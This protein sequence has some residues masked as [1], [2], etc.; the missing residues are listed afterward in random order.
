MKSESKTISNTNALEA[1]ITSIIA[2]LGYELVFAEITRS[3][4]RKLRLFIDHADSIDDKKITL[5]DCVTVSRAL[6]EPL[7]SSPQIDA[8]FGDNAYELEVSSPGIDRPLRAEADYNKFKGKTARIHVFR[9]LESSEIENLNYKEKNPRQKNF[10]GTLVGLESGKVIL[11]VET[12]SDLP[13]VKIPL[14]LIAKANLE[15]DFD[16]KELNKKSLRKEN[17]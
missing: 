16:F 8:V 4:Q 10:I 14:K 15:P 12:Q 11:K 1:L 7:E 2:P 6:N 9:P 3:G 17:I 13:D 5:E